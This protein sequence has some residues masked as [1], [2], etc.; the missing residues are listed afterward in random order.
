MELDG[1]APMMASPMPAITTMPVM[2][3]YN[4]SQITPHIFVTAVGTAQQI[5]KIMSNG[6]TCVINV[7]EELPQLFFPPQ[8]GIESLKFPVQDIPSYPASFYFDMVADR[9]DANVKANRRTLIYCHLGQS[10]SVTFTLAYLIK[11]YR[12]PL[13]YAYAMVKGRR[14][15][16][17]PNAGFW[18]QLMFYEAQQRQNQSQASLQQPSNV[19]RSL[20]NIPAYGQQMLQKFYHGFN[21]VLTEDPLVHVF[22]HSINRTDPKMSLRLNFPKRS[23]QQK[24]YHR[25]ISRAHH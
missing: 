17:L 6:I 10:R 22:T 1:K 21:T 14:P 23:P 24:P 2:V 19:L 5:D 18:A 8:S 20:Q 25:S 12:Y 3:D 13:S 15:S 9:I 7:A 11:Y 4:M 16:A